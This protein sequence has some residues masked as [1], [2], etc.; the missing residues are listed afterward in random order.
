MYKWS[1]SKPNPVVAYIV[2]QL[3]DTGQIVGYNH[4]PLCQKNSLEY[5][6]L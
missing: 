2:M 4:S 5:V 3:Y 6:E 1:N